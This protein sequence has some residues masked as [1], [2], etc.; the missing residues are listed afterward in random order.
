MILRNFF[1]LFLGLTTVSCAHKAATPV[2]ASGDASAVID[3]YSA[4]EAYGEFSNFALYPIYLDG[5]WWPTSEHYYQAHKYEDPQ[6][7]EWVRLAPTPKEAA[8]RGRDTSV[9][10]RADWEQKKDEFM[11]IAVSAKFQRYPELR[12]LLLSTGSAQIYEH[13]TKDCYWGDC[14]NRTGKNKL[15]LL[16]EKIR[17]QLQKE[18]SRVSPGS[19]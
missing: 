17:A 7:I 15:G 14:G 5:Q 13:T 11:E 12:D 16:L 2:P 1:R 18:K 8:N 19:P 4:R 6:L 3:F 9:P 10:K